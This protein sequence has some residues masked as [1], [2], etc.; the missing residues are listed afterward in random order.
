IGDLSSDFGDIK[1]IWELSRFSFVYPLVRAYTTTKDEKYAIDFWEMFE[2]FV[3][4][5]P[6]E[7]GAN[8]KC[9]QEMSFRIMAWT[10]GLNIF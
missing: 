5:N 3:K 7:L 8:Y 1:W 6:P 10:F 9:G 2:D 4:H